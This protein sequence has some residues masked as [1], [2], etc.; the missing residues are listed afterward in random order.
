MGLIDKVKTMLA[1]SGE[2]ETVLY[3]LHCAD[4]DATYMAETPPGSAT[5]EECGSSDLSEESRMYAGSPA[6]GG[7]G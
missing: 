5:C 3:E 6:G 7:V 2:D 1:P 4:C